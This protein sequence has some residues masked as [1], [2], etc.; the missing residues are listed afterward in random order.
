MAKRILKTTLTT[1]TEAEY[2]EEEYEEDF[3]DDDEEDEKKVKGSPRMGLFQ[4]LKL[5]EVT[6]PC[7]ETW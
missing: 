3:E 6:C 7:V 4:L 1:A 2:D 5:A